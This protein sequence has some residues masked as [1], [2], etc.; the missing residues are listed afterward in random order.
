[1]SQFIFPLIFVFAFLGAVMLVQG[2]AALVF[3]GREKARRV[4]RRLS[5]LESGMDRREVYE[6]LVRRPA[7]PK[8]SSLALVRAHDRAAVY[9]QQA[10]VSV[11][12]MRV[13]AY[14]IAA[15]LAMWGLAIF[16]LRASGMAVGPREMILSLFGAATIAGYVGWTWVAGRRIK[17]LKALEEQLPLALDIV[18]RA[19]RA[20]HPVVSAVQLV[21]EEMGDPIGS[22]FGV[23][24]DETTYGVEFREALRNFARRTG[25]E[26]AHFFAVSVGIQWET[27]GNLAEILSNLA[28]VIRARIMLGRRV[29][30]LSSEGRMSAWILSGLPVVLISFLSLTQPQFYTSKFDNPVFWPIVSGIVVLYLLGLLLMRS[31]INFK[32]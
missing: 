13:A 23:I 5:M 27:G 2:A 30:A 25:S 7:S 17:R 8:F 9:L 22:E 11:P 10:G 24:V 15:A 12:P 31:I 18:I 19:L 20:G 32:Y 1:M 21:T 26:D 3:A 6:T 29:R 14:A 4:N 28:N 16:V